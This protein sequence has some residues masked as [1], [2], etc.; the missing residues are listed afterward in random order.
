MYGSGSRSWL[1]QASTGLLLLLLAAWH[2]ARVHL[3]GSVGGLP[4]YGEAVAVFKNPYTAALAVLFTIL[5]AF[6]A[7]NGVASV[8]VEA[9]VDEKKSS[10]AA[11]ILWIAVSIYVAL[12]AVYAAL[13]L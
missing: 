1:L 8:L 13:F 10:R 11:L 7:F 5:V 4:S 2:M 3:G 6:H 12:L 9:G